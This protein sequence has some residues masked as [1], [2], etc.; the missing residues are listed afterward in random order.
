MKPFKFPQANGS[1]SRP[2]G[3]AKDEC[4]LLPVHRDGNYVISAWR[5]DADDLKLIAEEKT[6]WLYVRGSTQPPI[7]MQ[8]ENP[9]DSTWEEKK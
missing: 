5:L 8:V 9:W 6:I 1:L 2:E 3:V 4:G 7:S